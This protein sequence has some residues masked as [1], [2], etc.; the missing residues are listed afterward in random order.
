MQSSRDRPESDD[1]RTRITVTV[2]DPG[3]TAELLNC[4]LE[5]SEGADSSQIHISATDPQEVQTVT[6]DG[7]TQKQRQAVLSATALGYYDDP[8]SASLG[9]VAAELD[10]SDSAASKRL[11]TVERKLVLALADQLSS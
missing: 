10:V 1:S 2:S 7:L 9:D 4:L 6:V 11:K 5:Q 8:R 3:A